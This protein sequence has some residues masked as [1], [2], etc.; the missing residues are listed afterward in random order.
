MPSFNRRKVCA[1][2]VPK[3]SAAP[4]RATDEALPDVLPRVRAG[5]HLALARAC[6]VPRRPM[7][8]HGDPA[9]PRLRVHDALAGWGTDGLVLA[10]LG[11]AV[12]M[13]ERHPAIYRR[14]RQRL[15]EHGC[16]GA[17]DGRGPVTAALE[18]AR[19]RWRGGP[20]FDVVYLDPVFGPHPKTAA[21]SRHMQLLRELAPPLEGVGA[22]IA[23]ACAVAGDRVVVKRRRSERAYGTPAWQVAA[24]TVRF[25]VY[26]PSVDR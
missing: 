20:A 2:Q 22:L 7:A 21:A 5:R 3:R 12:H 25:D 24:K 15:Q 9:V 1:S 8:L 26:R 16:G 18:D 11:C 10:G 23:L 14:L 19:E 13:S 6:G 17:A 4:P